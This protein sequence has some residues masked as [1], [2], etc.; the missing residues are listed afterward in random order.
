[1]AQEGFEFRNGE[2]VVYPTHGVGQVLSTETQTIAG[3]E[4]KV[5]VISF[6]KD[7]MTLRLPVT[8]A[9]T[10]GLRRLSS[11]E[12]MQS[13][14]RPSFRAAPACVARCGAA[15]PR[16]MK[17]KSIRVTLRPSPKCC[18]ICIRRP[19]LPSN[20]TANARFIRQRW[21][22]WCANSPPLNGSTKIRPPKA[23]NLAAGRLTLPHQSEADAS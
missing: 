5:I 13:A 2:F 19:G 11:E 22:V 8:K 6:E 9:R 14:T 15:A 4:L 16:N 3:H 7:R 1:M 12:E 21:I 23:G 17:P 20:P 10:S 18:A